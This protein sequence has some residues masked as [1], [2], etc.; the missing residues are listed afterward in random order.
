MFV[1]LISI[2]LYLKVPIRVSGTTSQVLEDILKLMPLDSYATNAVCVM[3]RVDSDKA[4]DLQVDAYTLLAAASG[5]QP[6]ELGF[7]ERFRFYDMAKTAAV[8]IQTDDKALYANAIVYKG[9]L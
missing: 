5:L 7:I 1:Y 6:N 9:V 8:I 3:D 4:K 2:A